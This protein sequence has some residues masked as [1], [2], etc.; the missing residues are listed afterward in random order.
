MAIR[1]LDPDTVEKIAAGEVV[2]RP[3]SVVK[4]LVE[5][6]IDAGADRIEV[7]IAGGGVELIRVRDNGCGMSREDAELAFQRH[8]TSKIGHID[9]LERVTTLGFRGEALPSIAAVSRVEMKTRPRGEISGTAIVIEGGEVKKVEEAGCPEGTAVAVRNLFYNTPARRKFLKSHLT[10]T[11]HCID[12]VTRFALAYP[13]ISFRLT[14]DGREALNLPATRDPRERIMGLYGP[15]VARDMVPLES[16]G[17]FAIMGSISRPST[18]RS[19]RDFMSV[20]VN[21]RYVKS[22]LVA[23]AIAE[24]YRTL[25]PRGRYPIAVINIDIDPSRI[26][27]NVHP[28][29]VEVK[30]KDEKAVY[31]AVAD[32]IRDALK[33]TRLAP[34]IAPKEPR[35]TKP[36]FLVPPPAEVSGVKERPAAYAGKARKEKPTKTPPKPPEPLPDLRPIGQV[37]DS[38]IIAEHDEGL[39]IIDQHAAHERIRFEAILEKREGARSQELL[40]PFVF[41]ASPK[42]AAVLEGNL[43]L[44]AEMGFSVEPMGGRSFAVK[45]LPV[46]FGRIEDH[47]TVRDIISELGA[48]GEVKTLEERREKLAAIMACRSAVKAG[49]ALLPDSM[50][51]LIE[52]L[53]RTKNPHTCPHGRPTI[54]E[55]ELSELERRFG[56]R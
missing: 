36:T 49:D 54:I 52:A 11:T 4:E 35:M 29:K 18:T 34:R 46:V 1:V 17:D 15:E 40:S 53:G 27:V 51:R 28:A 42:E 6:S 16:G 50:E 38:Y 55:M 45:A 30:F 25:L 37:H 7:E 19:S 32:A 44:L 2:E 56:R 13:G 39:V 8:A 3:A 33:G 26:D 47:K 43:S 21:R 24:G 12:V 23:R 14:R 9:D 41:D 22:P 31:W 20:Y 5:N 48:L 10:E